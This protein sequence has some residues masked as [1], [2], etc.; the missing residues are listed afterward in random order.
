MKTACPLLLASVVVIAAAL[1]T[2]AIR[3]KLIPVR[4]DS[5]IFLSNKSCFLF[6][7]LQR[8]FSENRS[9]FSDLVCFFFLC[10]QLY[11]FIA[12]YHSYTTILIFLIGSDSTGPAQI[13]NARLL[14]FS[15]TDLKRY[16]GN[17][18]NQLFYTKLYFL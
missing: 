6:S 3:K 4:T 2:P 13:S 9:S 11:V 10:P 1:A 17:S 18:K 14:Q 15:H 5:R 8:M 7:L 12:F 16:V